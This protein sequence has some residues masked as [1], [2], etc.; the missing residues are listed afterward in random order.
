MECEMC[1]GSGFVDCNGY[2]P[3]H[4]EYNPRGEC[5][6]CHGVRMHPC[7]ACMVR[8][9]NLTPHPVSVD[10]MTYAPSGTVARV[11]QKEGAVSDLTDG[12]RYMAKA[13]EAPVM[14]PVEDLPAPT[15]YRFFIVS[16]MVLNHPDVRGRR[17]VFA[18]DTSPAAVIRDKDGRVVGT[19][20]F[21][22]APSRLAETY[23][24]MCDCGVRY[25]DPPN[26][27]NAGCRSTGF[28]PGCYDCQS[29]GGGPCHMHAGGYTPSAMSRVDREAIQRVVAHLGSA[30]ERLAPGVYRDF[31]HAC[32]VLEAVLRLQAI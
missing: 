9:V 12:A 5:F 6:D 13:V 17:D 28:D 4:A 25:D 18:P 26:Q 21:V 1:S 16:G 32:E 23:R 3:S 20:R 2:G 27:H 30:A 11:S 7:E 15:P 31:D 10:G 29:G 14:G 24:V 22:R 19:T 8:F